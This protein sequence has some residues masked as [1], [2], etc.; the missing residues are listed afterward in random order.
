MT[1][2]V[3]LHRTRLTLLQESLSLDPPTSL[4][5]LFARANKYVL[6]MEVM[7][8]I[9]GNEDREQKRKERD[10]EE[11]CDAPFPLTGATREQLTELLICPAIREG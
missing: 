1:M 4:V 10:V 9:G 2:S 11:D 6:H 5:D 8:V 7:R 3:M